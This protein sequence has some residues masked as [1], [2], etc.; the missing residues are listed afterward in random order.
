MTYYVSSGTSNLTHSPPP[1]QRRCLNNILVS[2]EKIGLCSKQHC[3]NRLSYQTAWFQPTSP[4]MVSAQL[5]QHRR[6]PTSCKPVQMGPCQIRRLR[7]RHG[8]E[9]NK[10]WRQFAITSRGEKQYVRNWLETLSN[11][12]HSRNEWNW[13]KEIMRYGLWLWNSVIADD[14]EQ[15]FKVISVI[16]TFPNSSSS[17][18]IAHIMPWLHV[19]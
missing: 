19:K 4:C 1:I 5:L 8:V 17:K 16:T 3:C 7:M 10:T 18:I 13:L 14:M 9:I 6:R 2:G 11:Y 15:H 12:W